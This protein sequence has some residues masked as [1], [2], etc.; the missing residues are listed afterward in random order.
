MVEESDPHMFPFDFVTTIVTVELPNCYDVIPQI[1]SNE[2]ANGSP[3]RIL[4]S[5]NLQ[6]CLTSGH[7][8]VSTKFIRQISCLEADIHLSCQE[9]LRRVCNPKVQYCL[10]KRSHWA[11]SLLIS[12]PIILFP[13][14]H[15]PAYLNSFICLF[16]SRFIIDELFV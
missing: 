16:S 14:S 5:D 11:L 13:G 4:S 1:L 8:T 10:F 2:N 15:I 3:K 12:L 9:T 6:P 7:S